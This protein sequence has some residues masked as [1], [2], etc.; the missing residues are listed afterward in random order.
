MVSPS[1][2][3]RPTSRLRIYTQWQ[4]GYFSIQRQTPP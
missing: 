1:P 3:R 4:L 2:E